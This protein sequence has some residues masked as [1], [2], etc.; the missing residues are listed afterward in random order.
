MENNA[1]R[2]L[3]NIAKK[4]LLYNILPHE[5]HVNSNH[6]NILSAWTNLQKWKKW[7]WEDILKHWKIY[8]FLFELASFFIISI[9]EI[10][11]TEN[12][13]T[14]ILKTAFISRITEAA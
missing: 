12:A 8:L 4:I 14:K 6:L 5:M 10:T 2:Y 9:S 3:S 1:L 7:L 13:A 11:K